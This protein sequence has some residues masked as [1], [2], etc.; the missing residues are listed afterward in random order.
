MYAQRTQIRVPHA[1]MPRLR[2]MIDSEYLPVVSRRPGFVAA[3]L[4][5]KVDDEEAAEMIL[6]W[7]S[8]SAAESFTRTGS[9]AASLQ[10]LAMSIPGLKIQRE[11]YIVRVM[12]GAHAAE[13]SYAQR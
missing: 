3:Y 2:A 6:L 4:L 5:E 11:G 10:A 8:H 12:S 7:D 13:A 1:C 9:L